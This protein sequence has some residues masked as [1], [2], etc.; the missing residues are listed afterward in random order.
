MDEWGNYPLERQKLF[1]LIE[2]TGAEGVVLLTGNVHFSEVS[3]LETIFYPIFDFTASGLD[4]VNE[5]Y[6]NAPNKYRV[7]GPCVV[8]N[9]GLVE[10]DWDTKL[11]PQVTFK[12]IGLDGSTAFDHQI[13][14]D[15]LH[16]ANEK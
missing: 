15:E 14:L 1:D 2:S 16:M 8:D 4:H 12:A 13:N 9:F 5:K 11:A 6:A 10:I 3:K 7:S